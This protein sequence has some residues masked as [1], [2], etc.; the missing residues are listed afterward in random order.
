MVITLSEEECLSGHG[1]PFRAAVLPL[2][3]GMPEQGPIP[4]GADTDKVGVSLGNYVLWPLG[5]T[6]KSWGFLKSIIID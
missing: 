3:E 2:E 6:V 5:V 4:K 1:K